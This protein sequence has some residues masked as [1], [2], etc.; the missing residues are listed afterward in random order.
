M[1]VDWYEDFFEGI[2][3]D[4]WDAAIPA[5]RTRE[6]ADFLQRALR[7]PP[8]GQVLDVPCGLG[9]HAV[10]LAS[11]GYRVTGVDLAPE[12]IA[13]ARGR[14]SGAGQPVEWRQADMRDLPWRSRFDA[15]YCFGNSFAYIDAAGSRAFL[16]AVSGALRP[17]ARFALDT[18]MTAESILPRHKE[19]EWARMGDILFLEENRYHTTQSCVET[20][21]TFVRGGERRS[22][23]GVHWIF[24][25][26][27]VQAMLAE[28][29]LV[30]EQALG[31]LEGGDFQLGSDYLILVAE[32]R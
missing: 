26:R 24:T 3:L 16:Q 17:G 29:G 6:E 28:A 10:E 2:V 27:E 30:V 1:N 31:S 23:T 7:L 4:A 9:R 20:T 13:R 19:R 11:R 15:A 18:G 21:Y 32:K 14:A 25:A 22:R 5:Q 12:A 8:S